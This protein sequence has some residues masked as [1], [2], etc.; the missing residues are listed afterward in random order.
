MGI[1]RVAAH[2]TPK[3]LGQEGTSLAYRNCL[4]AMNISL[5]SMHSNSLNMEVDGSFHELESA[6]IA[7]QL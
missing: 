6:S 7:W 2:G 3:G 5:P 4:H 1:G